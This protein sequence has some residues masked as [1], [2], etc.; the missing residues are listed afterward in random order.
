MNITRIT[1]ITIG[2]TLI[3]AISKYGIYTWPFRTLG[4]DG[5]FHPAIMGSNLLSILFILSPILA[6]YFYRQNNNVCYFWLGLFALPAFMFGV[7]PIPFANYLYTD[8]T[9]INGVFIAMIDIALVAISWF[10]YRANKA[11]QS[12]PKSGATV[13]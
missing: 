5:F 11:L 8:N 1:Q 7:V 9:Q 13:L 6:A 4:H 12:T 10:L 2:L 3:T